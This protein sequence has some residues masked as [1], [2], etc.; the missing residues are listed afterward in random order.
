MFAITRMGGKVGIE[1]NNENG[2]YVFKMNGKNYHWIKTLLPEE[3]DKP[4]GDIHDTKDKVKTRIVAPTTLTDKRKTIDRH[5]IKGLKIMLATDNILPKTSRMTRDNFEEGAYH[6]V[7]LKII[8][9]RQRMADSITCYH[10]LKWWPLLS[11][12][13]WE[14]ETEVTSLFSTKTWDQEE[15]LRTIQNLWLR[16]IHYLFP[17]EKM[18]IEKKISCIS[19]EGATCKRK[20]AKILE[21]YVSQLR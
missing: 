2:H 5:I 17:M 20:H 21:Y 1:L 19:K 10:H 12:I 18:C 16:S 3:G 4:R 8:S 7:K 9:K 11:M 14:M 6:G 13:Q 15:H